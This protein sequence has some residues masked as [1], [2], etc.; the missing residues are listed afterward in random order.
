MIDCNRQYDE[1]GNILI[2]FDCSIDLP[3]CAF[4]EAGASPTEM[5]NACDACYEEIYVGFVYGTCE[6]YSKP[7]VSEGYIPCDKWDD[8]EGEGEYAACPEYYSAV[9]ALY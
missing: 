7:P 9:C 1:A 2:D 4:S 6:D 3:V 5:G 8:I